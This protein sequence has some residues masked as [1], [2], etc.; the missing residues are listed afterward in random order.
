MDD[1][2]FF[3]H[4]LKSFSERRLVWALCGHQWRGI[5]NLRQAFSWGAD[6]WFLVNVMAQGDE[7]EASKISRLKGTCV[8]KMGHCHFCFKKGGISVVNLNK[9]DE[10]G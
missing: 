3:A 10:E 6:H 5:G 4:F 8:T 1:P 2:E 7:S 9:R